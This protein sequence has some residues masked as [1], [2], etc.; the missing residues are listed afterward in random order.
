MEHAAQ[1]QTQEQSSAQT[2]TTARG[3]ARPATREDLLISFLD[4]VIG[5]LGYRAIAV[6][7]ETHRAKT[8]R[9]FIERLDGVTVGIEDCVVVT[10][11]LDAPLEGYGE[12]DAWFRTPYELE[13]SSPG[14]DRPLRTAEDFAKYAG[15]RARIHTFRPLTAVETQNAPYTAKNP[16]QKNFIGTLEGMRGS[17]VA[18]T[19]EK[20]L[21][22]IPWTLVSKSNL[23]PAFDLDA[24]ESE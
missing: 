19:V 11:A 14:T 20:N 7:S 6:E 9:V 16:K 2:H 23:E 22:M 24:N 5:P 15:S 8:L 4:S 13:V 12:T 21:V 1:N 10:K 3:S 18:L 17:S